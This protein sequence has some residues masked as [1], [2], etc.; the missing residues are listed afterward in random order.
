MKTSDI[1]FLKRIALD[2][3]NHLNSRD[4]ID[5][6]DIT[7][8]DERFNEMKKAFPDLVGEMEAGD[9]ENAPQNK[10]HK[11]SA[12]MTK[13]RCENMKLEYEDYVKATQ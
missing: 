12:M 6:I 3:E 8:F 5:L 13:W 2:I 4:G 11:I 10:N 9:H 1:Q 7:K